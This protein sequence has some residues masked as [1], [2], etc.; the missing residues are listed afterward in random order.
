VSP[1]QT[2][3][4]NVTLPVRVARTQQPPLPAMGEAIANKTLD[5]LTPGQKR[6]LRVLL[7][8]DNHA[9]TDVERA[10]LARISQASWHRITADP[11]FAA[12]ERQ[13]VQAAVRASVGAIVHKS[14][15]VAT[16]CGR[17][18]TADRWK[19]LEMS[20]HY[21]PRQQ[22]ENTGGVVVGV[23]GVAMSDL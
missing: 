22:V 9:K 21:T 14:I 3:A 13:A 18:G 15:E 19:L 10:Q 20:G 11:T 12:I 8:P 1:T 4:D 6:V 5:D 7:D 16:T 17:D 23:V 2:H